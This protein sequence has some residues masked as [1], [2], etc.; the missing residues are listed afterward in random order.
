MKDGRVLDIK[1]LDSV[2]QVHPVVVR[3]RG[4]HTSFYNSKAMELAHITRDTPNPP[5]GTFDRDSDGALNGRVTDRAMQVFAGVGQRP[6]Y[7]PEQMLERSQAA[8]KSREVTLQVKNLGNVKGA[9]TSSVDWAKG[10]TFESTP[11][12]AVSDLA[13]TLQPTGSKGDSDEFTLTVTAPKDWD[14][15]NMGKTGTIIVTISGEATS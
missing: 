9:L 4:G 1:A 3:H 6:R 13:D 8:Q 7:T 11:K 15:S 2:S 10:A 12:A 5:G 14:A